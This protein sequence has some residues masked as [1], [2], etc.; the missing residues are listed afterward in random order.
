MAAQMTI[1]KRAYHL[2]RGLQNDEMCWLAG[3]DGY[4]FFREETSGQWTAAAECL[5]SWGFARLIENHLVLT[6][7]GK[8]YRE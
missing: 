6:E 4:A 1:G 2:L 3:G 5:I 8:A 7:Q